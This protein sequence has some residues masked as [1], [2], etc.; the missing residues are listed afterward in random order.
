M[1]GWQG[2][3]FSISAASARATERQSAGCCV[4]LAE[5][6]PGALEEGCVAEYVVRA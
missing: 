2:Q 3:V 6:H 4:Q 1:S 5:L